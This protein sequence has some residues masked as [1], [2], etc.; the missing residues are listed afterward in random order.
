MRPLGAPVEVLERSG[1]TTVARLV[2][3]ADDPVFAGHFPG[4]PILPGVRLVEFAHR[5]ATVDRPSRLVGVESCR[6]LRPVF[7]G[8]VL[9]AR[10][11]RDDSRC[12]AVVSDAD[13]VVAR[14]T[15]RYE[16]V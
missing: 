16:A 15:L 8:A 5:A 14:I 7:P 1:T 13:G 3:A 11:T 10:L 2:V 9:T 4:L 6:F 12:A